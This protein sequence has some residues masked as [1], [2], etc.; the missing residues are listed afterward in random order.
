MFDQYHQQLLHA[1]YKYIKLTITLQ[2]ISKP[3]LIYLTWIAFLLNDAIV[4]YIFGLLSA[5]FHHNEL[6]TFCIPTAAY[7][8]YN[9]SLYGIIGERLYWVLANCGL[10][11]APDKEQM[12]K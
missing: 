3:N 11:I 7:I 6:I 1:F 4:Q 10:F 8:L 9:N 2:L 12:Y 5:F